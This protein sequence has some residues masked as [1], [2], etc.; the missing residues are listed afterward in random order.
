M[1]T[2]FAILAMILLAGVAGA[3]D[4]RNCQEQCTFD[5]IVNY[6]CAM[7]CW[8]SEMVMEIYRLQNRPPCPYRFRAVPADEAEAWSAKNPGW[9]WGGAANEPGWIMQI[10]TKGSASGATMFGS[11]HVNIYFKRRVCEGE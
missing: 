4:D 10:I 7:A 5:G 9:E 6:T 11:E 2:L 1:K 3:E 8:E